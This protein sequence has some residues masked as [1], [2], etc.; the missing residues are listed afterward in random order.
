MTARQAFSRTFSLSILLAGLLVSGFSSYA[1][2]PS[3]AEQAK[4]KKIA[5][6]YAQHLFVSMCANNYRGEFPVSTLSAAD[7][8]QLNAHTEGACECFYDRVEKVTE[9]SEVTDYV[10]YV[11]GVHPTGGV[12][13][14]AMAYFSAKQPHKI[15]E[16]WQDKS[17]TKKCGFSRKIDSLK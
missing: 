14:D 8:A 11:Y 2:Q 3:Q 13:P 1:Q 6:A 15:G 7:K 4:N 16:L 10:M 12:D 5:E 9:P 17:L